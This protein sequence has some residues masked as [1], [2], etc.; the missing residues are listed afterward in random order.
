MRCTHYQ[1]IQIDGPGNIGLNKLKIKR[2]VNPKRLWRAEGIAALAR[3]VWTRFLCRMHYAFWDRKFEALEKVATRGTVHKNDLSPVNL[4]NAHLSY[5]YGASP[6]LVISWILSA[7][8]VDESHYTFVD[9]G[10]GR[11]R[12]LL[13]AA[14]RPFKSIHGIEFCRLLQT[15]SKQNLD[16]YPKHK[17]VCQDVR[18]ICCDVLEY[19]P[20]NTD[21]ILYFYNPFEAELLDNVVRNFLDMAQEMERNIIVI[22]YNAVHHQTLIRDTRLKPKSLPNNLW[23]KLKLL[24]PHPVQ[25]YDGVAG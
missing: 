15:Q 17:L 22:Y 1:W 10:S 4:T 24:S 16:E 18:S 8:D 12:I 14:E 23:L 25:I 13:A 3:H 20:P 7:I 21:I 9:V 5:E 2:V 11:G 6:R 19:T